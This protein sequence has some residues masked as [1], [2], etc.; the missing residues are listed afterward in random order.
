MCYAPLLLFSQSAAWQALDSLA[1][2][3]YEL[4]EYKEGFVTVQKCLDLVKK[5][6]LP[7]KIQ[8]PILLKEALFTEKLGY[9]RKADTLIQEVVRLFKAKKQTTHSDYPAALNAAG[10]IQMLLGGYDNSERFLLQSKMVQEFKKDTL[11]ILYAQTMDYFGLLMNDQAQYQQAIKYYFSANN[12][13]TRLKEFGHHYGKVMTHFG[14]THLEQ[15]EYE[16]AIKK[17]EG[18]R[19]M[20]NKKHVYY[21][22]L[23]NNLGR[24]FKSIG[25]Y[26]AA[27]LAYDTSLVKINRIVGKKHPIYLRTQF[28]L[29]TLYHSLGNYEKATTLFKN[30]KNQFESANLIYNDI[31][32]STLNALA[33]SYKWLGIE[34]ALIPELYK[35]SAKI[36]KQRND[37]SSYSAAN[38]NLGYH[39]FLAENYKLAIPYYKKALA[40]LE[41]INGDKQLLSIYQ[42]GLA[43]VFFKTN[44][45]I[46]ADSIATLS[47]QGF[48]ATVS[49]KHPTYLELASTL[50]LIKEA[51]NEKEAAAKIYKVNANILE[52]QL[53]YYYPSLSESER[54]QFYYTIKDQFALIGS[55]IYR[56]PNIYQSLQNSFQQLNLNI[57]GLALEST[58]ISREETLLSQDSLIKLQWQELVTNRRK[59]A[60]L[61]FL[62]N[63]EKKA[64]NKQLD[65]LIERTNLLEKKISRANKKSISAIVENGIQFSTW[66]NHI[67]NNEIA[68]DF[69][70]FEYNDAQDWTYKNRYIVLVTKKTSLFS[71][72]YNI[73]EEEYLVELLN[74]PS[75]HESSYLQSQ[76]IKNELYKKIWMPIETELDKINKVHLST[77]SWINQISF[78]VLRDKNGQL[79]LSK[80]LFIYYQNLKELSKR[81]KINKLKNNG[82][83][84]IG[85][86]DYGIETSNNASKYRGTESIN[87]RG[88]SF[89]Y[90]PGTLTEI[91]SI[92]TKFSRTSKVSILSDSIATELNLKKKLEESA[93]NIVHIATHGYFFNKPQKKKGRRKIKDNGENRVRNSENP[94]IRSG[95]AL[96]NINKAWRS[97]KSINATNDGILTAYEI[98]NLNLKNTDLAVLSAC[99]TGLGDYREGEGVFGLQRAF[100]IAGV[101]SL[102]ISLWKVPDGETSQMMSSFYRHYLD[103]NSKEQSLQKAQKQM[104]KTLSPIYWGGFILLE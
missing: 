28:N 96:S 75:T 8:L 39:F 1:A 12:I 88:S 90:L 72:V 99:D 51:M 15:G 42:Y 66:R 32:S 24:Y 80:Y 5:A 102:L 81:K 101:K 91:Q 37:I 50:S 68:L 13:L 86:I 97:E 3:Q 87:T 70:C 67:S 63:K 78:A 41:K 74:K 10:H 103:G 64:K 79:L 31:Y 85:D 36:A 46:Q 22:I 49:D 69:I 100:K 4:G 55:F 20:L 56:H 19:K 58:L 104:S 16:K 44:K 17:F 29:G 57:K 73:G 43:K 2:E 7:V 61:F 98:C 11:T 27:E 84:I 76:L 21:G 9:Y 94:L 77:C 92:Q 60:N 83:L 30:I 45:L 40:S 18:A 26:E 89:N 25:E 54:L 95:L 48:A 38:Y 71:K 33:L 65:S 53:L 59:I 52:E 35:K 23:Q 47:V 34:E 93:Y 82:A 6:Q 14:E 62:A